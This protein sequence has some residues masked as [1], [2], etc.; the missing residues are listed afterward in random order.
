MSKSLSAGSLRFFILYPTRP[1]IAL[2]SHL[3]RQAFSS[4]LFVR[5]SSVQHFTKAFSSSVKQVFNC[6]V[7]RS[8]FEIDET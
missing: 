5:C 6:A 2:R 7:N 8:P 1:L 4:V 3:A